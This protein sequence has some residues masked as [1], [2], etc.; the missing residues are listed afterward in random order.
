MKPKFRTAIE[1][2]AGI[3]S[4]ATS[5]LEVAFSNLQHVAGLKNQGFLPP[6]VREGFPKLIEELDKL[7]AALS[8]M[9][10]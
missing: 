5:E 9:Q 2:T 6:A 8:Q 4:Q 3:V 10:E 1:N 7:F